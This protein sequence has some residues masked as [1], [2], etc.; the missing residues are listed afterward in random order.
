MLE[1]KIVL[2]AVFERYEVE[3]VGERPEATRRRSI[4]FSPSRGATVLLRDRAREQADNSQQPKPA[5]VA[6]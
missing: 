3:P 6:A 2:R 4:T 1:M 5:A